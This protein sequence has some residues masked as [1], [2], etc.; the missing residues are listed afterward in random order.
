MQSSK[1]RFCYTKTL[2]AREV[3]PPVASLRFDAK[4]RHLIIRNEPFMA[5]PKKEDSEKL[6]KSL[7]PVRCSENDY[8]AID[9]R[10]KQVSLSMSEFIR[11]AALG[12]KIIVRQSN[13]NFDLVQELKRSGNNLNQLA[14]LYH[15]TNKEPFELR[16][17]LSRHERVLHKIFEAL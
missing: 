8:R 6:T 4:G 16:E 17:A 13:T 14:K 2:L 15:S 3:R 5:R 12:H 1:I 9:A 11:E 7:P 10:A